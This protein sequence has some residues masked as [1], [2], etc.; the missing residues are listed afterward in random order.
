MSTPHD[1]NTAADA[2]FGEAGN[3]VRSGSRLW[4]LAD[5]DGE[6]AHYIRG[7]EITQVARRQLDADSYAVEVT[8]WRL[9]DLVIAT[10]AVQH[11]MAALTLQREGI[12]VID[13]E[14]NTGSP[15][16]GSVTARFSCHDH[17]RAQRGRSGRRPAP[18]GRGGR[19]R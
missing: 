3:A 11:L 8:L 15:S 2:A 14:G 18:A 19:G 12:V 17:R 9:P 16:S 1:E 13:G 7:D 10:D 5:V 6:D 4:V